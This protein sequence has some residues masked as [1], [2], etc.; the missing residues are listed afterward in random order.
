MDADTREAGSFR[1]VWP[2]HALRYVLITA[3]VLAWLGEVEAVRGVAVG[4]LLLSC[5]LLCDLPL[6][7]PKPV[8]TAYLW[9]ALQLLSVLSALVVAPGLPAALI[10]AAVLCGV[11]TVTAMAFV[12]AAGAVASAATLFLV[13]AD[14]GTYVVLLALYLLAVAVGRLYLQRSR[15]K[16]RNQR[17]V[18][19]LQEAQDRLTEYAEAMRNLAAVHE[20]QRLAEELHDTLGHALV[21]TLL[22]IQV[23]GKLVSKDPDK[24]VERLQVV[25][26]NV[27]KT[28]ED[29]R[30]ALRRGPARRGQLPLHL[31]LEGLVDDF[32]AAGG[33]R[34]ELLFHPDAEHFADVSK[35]VAD[36]LYRTAQ[37]ALTNAVRH[38]KATLIRVTVEAVGPRLYLRIVDNGIGADEYTPGM[39]LTGMVKRV[40]ALGGTMRFETAAGKGFQVEVGVM[41]R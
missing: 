29:V 25:E 16:R 3:G 38:G 37:E 1:E 39:G 35:D 18:E 40:Q 14:S 10:L 26:A 11:A 8:G 32:T 28:L 33:P 19:A 31:A 27:R 5:V 30:R 23:A 17:T 22:Q 34:V 9:A 24:V 41:R 6:H 4:S 2:L 7:A 15:E 21:A 12:G 13:H 20:R 36:A